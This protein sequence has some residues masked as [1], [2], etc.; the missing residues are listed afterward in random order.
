[1]RGLP[2]PLFRTLS[3]VSHGVMRVR[4]RAFGGYFRY[5]QLPGDPVV[6][7]RNWRVFAGM[8]RFEKVFGSPKNGP[9]SSQC[10]SWRFARRGARRLRPCSDRSSVVHMFFW[11]KWNG[12][13]ESSEYCV[14]AGLTAVGLARVCW[15][16]SQSN[17]GSP[18]DRLRA[19]GF[20]CRYPPTESDRVG[21]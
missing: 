19:N 9:L 15:M 11:G 13:A 14:G 12:E 2:D 16:V 1:M 21:E 8:R 18:F 7:G 6:V 3:N 5:E 10:V 20:L 4:L 17:H